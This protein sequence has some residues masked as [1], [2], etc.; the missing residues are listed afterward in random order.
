MREFMGANRTGVPRRQQETRYACGPDYRLVGARGRRLLTCRQPASSWYRAPVPVTVRTMTTADVEARMRRLR[1]LADGFWAEMAMIPK[2]SWPL[3]P[4]EVQRYEKAVKEVH[5]AVER[6][7]G[8]L[9]VAV[10]RMARRK[11]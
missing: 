7:H 9:Q 1:Q 4:Y 10:D 3:N 2:L 11:R 8:A 6:A 5:Q